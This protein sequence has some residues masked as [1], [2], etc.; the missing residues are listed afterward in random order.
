MVAVRTL[1]SGISRGTESL[2]FHGRV[3]PSQYDAMRC[4]FQEGQFPGPVKYGYMSVGVVE[5]NG[6]EP[7]DEALD[8]G[9]RV[10]CLFPH[11]DRYVVPRAAVR[12][13]PDGLPPERAVL[14]ANMET[15]VN[16]LWD[17]RLG[18]GDRILVVGAGVVGLLVARLCAQV[19][20][21][22]VVVVDPERSADV[23]GALGLDLRPHVPAGFEADL[24]FH[25]SGNPAGLV[26]ALDAAGTE[27]RIVEVSWFGD[28][29]VSL[30]LGE[31][32]H[33]RRLT[34]RSSQVGG[35]PLDRRARWDHGRRLD[36]ALQ[37]LRDSTL[38]ALFT[39]ESSF[40]D[41]PTTLAS[42]ARD[43][44]GVLC[45]RIRYGA[46]QPPPR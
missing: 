37:L 44:R 21:T 39:G 40:R 17:A 35:I 30:P 3:P 9:T 29:S 22:R 25:A 13:L 24:V 16:A 36:L 8:V 5:G 12:A 23:A 1:Y 31:A 33:A 6:G 43:G 32:F 41:L 20:G 28:Q 45:H 27:A 19:P 38:D 14:A 34:I 15:A 10:F 2:V 11:Q 46:P 7:A 26:D 4:P 42:L 18:L